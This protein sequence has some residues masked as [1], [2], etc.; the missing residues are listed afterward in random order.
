MIL[1]LY[2]AIMRLFHT[3]VPTL[4]W[5][6]AARG[7]ED[8]QRLNERL[9]VTTTARPD[10]SLIWFHGVSVGESVSALP[11]INQL[12]NDHP[13]L[14]I[15]ITTATTTSAEILSKRLPEGVIHQ[16]APVD[17]PQAVEAFL[18]HWRPDLAVYIESDIWPNQLIALDKR[19][20]P[21]LLISARITER[22]YKG[23]QAIKGPMSRLLK[24]FK[25][26]LPQDHESEARLKNMGV[27]VGP[28]GNLKTIGDALPD[29][30]AA[31]ETLEAQIK[32]RTVILAASTHPT[33][34]NYIA[35]ALEGT[36]RETGALLIVV[37]RHPVRAESIRLDLEALG[38][39]IA[40]RSKE[41]GPGLDSLT[42]AT[43]IYLADTLGE[44]GVFFRLA[45]MVIMAGSFS[46]K[47][48]GHNPLEAARLGKAVITGRDLYNWD[49]V[50]APM[51]DAGA[52]FKATD[53]ETLTFYV[54][55][56]LATPGAMLDANRSALALAQREAGT[57]S[58]VMAHLAPFI[59]E[60]QN[61][62]AIDAA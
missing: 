24:G 14:R 36:L 44:L 19:G 12:L 32:G 31:R 30:I 61:P 11:V 27:T 22:T 3:F 58:L 28:I 39:K 45:D 42:E 25:L 57:L 17:T 23:W 41:R 21:R 6:R 29:D 51:F 20:T 52:A 37:P 35:S 49:S 8:P 2:A 60:G 43:H 38:F 47:I 55:S 50:Y 4:L 5:Q 46:E 40:Q 13:G 48:G 26:V 1:S 7:K 15:L 34:E 54:Q 56:V 59:P 16:Y 53:R 18:N 33:E 9:G 62:G 10:G